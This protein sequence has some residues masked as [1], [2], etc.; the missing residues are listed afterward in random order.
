MSAGVKIIDGDININS[1]GAIEI[2][3]G[4]DKCLRDFGKMLQTST[5]STDNKTDLYR[6]N[7]NY[8]S[9]LDKL[10]GQG[11]TK[12]QILE[13][14]SELMYA[15]I[16]SYLKVQE[17]RQNLSSGEIIVDVKYDTFFDAYNPSVIIIPIKITNA[18]GITYDLGEFEQRIA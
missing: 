18:E 12:R 6:Y 10:I 15:T 16:Q 11:L 3:E 13:V 14:S 8:G 2:V 4:G 5:E 1:A 7:P 9:L 17:S